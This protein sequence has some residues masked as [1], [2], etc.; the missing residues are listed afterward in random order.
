MIVRRIKIVILFCICFLLQGNFVYLTAIFGGVPDLLLVL[1]L[2]YTFLD[3]TAS[4]DGLVA[5]TAAGLLKDICYGLI[6]GPTPL[7]YL[8]TGGLMFYMKRR[9]NNENGIIL[10]FVTV[11][12]T[13]LSSFGQW[14]L[15]VF[16][17]QSW[18][19]FTQVLIHL[20]GA[21]FWNFVILL[22]I[23][24][25]VKRRRRRSRMMF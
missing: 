2:T 24:T 7:I 9:L 16:F 10:F 3:E 21:V 13:V 1:L 8:A 5:A 14:L 12:A 11:V 18:L 23:N 20:P 22:I 4:Y 19:S 15:C 17:T 25:I 6:V